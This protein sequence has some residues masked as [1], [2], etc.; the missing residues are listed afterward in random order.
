MHGT[1]A[2][3]YA[4]GSSP[5]P[6]S[7]KYY[8][9]SPYAYCAGDP[10]NRVD[11]DGRNPIIGA[12]AGAGIDIGMQIATNLITGEKWYEI[13]GKSVAISAGAG[14]VGVGLSSKIKQFGNLAKISKA[15]VMATEVAAETVVS[16]TESAA[17]QYASDGTVSF[18]QVT[19]DA[20]TGAISSSVGQVAKH[21]KQIQGDSE[22]RV[23]KRQLDH[24][25]RVAGNN[26]RPSR[27]EKV[28][29]ARSKVE[30]YGNN[31]R[32]KANT[33]TIFLIEAS[34]SIYEENNST[35]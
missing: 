13:D 15:A 29:T 20:T 17:K 4:A 5:T 3:R 12:L 24:A 30:D 23:L 32:D 31:D 22:Y 9:I 6:L 11:P 26:P 34:K 25:E 21:I 10:V 18:K 14:A 1:T 35:Q 33:L 19:F 16:G 8:G 28:N 2:P 7:E 27:Q